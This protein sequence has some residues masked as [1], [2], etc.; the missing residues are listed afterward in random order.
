[1]RA[2]AEHD[3]DDEDEIVHNEPYPVNKTE[4][5][6]WARKAW[7]IQAGGHESDGEWQTHCSAICLIE[8]ESYVELSKI[9]DVAAEQVTYRQCATKDMMPHRIE[10]RPKR[11]FKQLGV[12]EGYMRINGHKAHVL[13]DRGSMLDMI[14]ANFAAVHKLNMFQLKKPSSYKWRHLAHNPLST[15]ELK[16]SSTLGS[17]KVNDTLM[18]ST[19]TDTKLS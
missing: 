2:Y 11:N 7:N 4:L 5:Q 13:L 15:M 9:N 17:L 16:Q 1:M 8:E 19:L 10:D 14:S 3:E 18:S 12:I 6:D